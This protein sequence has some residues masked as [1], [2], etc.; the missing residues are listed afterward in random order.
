M[1]L[2]QI[3]NVYIKVEVSMHTSASRGKQI[4]SDPFFFY[5]LW[6][7]IICYSGPVYFVMLPFMPYILSTS[8]VL[9]P[10]LRGLRF[11]PRRYTQTDRSQDRRCSSEVGKLHSS[12]SVA[13]SVSYAMMSCLKL[14]TLQ[15]ESWVLEASLY[16]DTS[17]VQLHI[18]LVLKATK[19]SY[20]VYL[21]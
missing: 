18:F 13:E 19:E 21:T 17:L 5:F 11:M 12:R 20:F 6:F 4:Q 15:T 8:L 2:R 16:Y 14:E 10:L 1:R 3:T 7:L 9:T